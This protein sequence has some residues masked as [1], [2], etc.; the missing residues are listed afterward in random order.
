MPTEEF[1]RAQFAIWETPDP[2]SWFTTA[3]AD[4]IKWIVPGKTN[5]LAGVYT[6]REQVLGVFGTLM[7]KMA[8][9]PETKVENVIASGDSAVVEMSFKAPT[10]NP[11][12]GYDGP[13]FE[14]DMCWVCK[15]EGEKI[16][17]LHC[18]IDTLGEKILFAQE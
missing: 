6:S 11:L 2:V 14:Q 4:N 13:G 17:E 5:P 15:Y 12:P 10:K 7:S 18:Y 8:G 16:V 1:V 3:L 9:P